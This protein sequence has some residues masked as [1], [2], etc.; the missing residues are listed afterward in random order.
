MVSVMAAVDLGQLLQ[1]KF[2]QQSITRNRVGPL[3]FGIAAWKSKPALLTDIFAMNKPIEKTGVK[4]KEPSS[5]QILCDAIGKL[6][7]S[8]TA[9][10]PS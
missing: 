6:A 9:P 10:T 4:I 5:F 2:G 1:E 8:G 7:K 3:N